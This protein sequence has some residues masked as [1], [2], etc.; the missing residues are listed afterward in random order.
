MRESPAVS[1][2]PLTMTVRPGP[3]ASQCLT[4]GI[5]LGSTAAVSESKPN[6]TFIALSWHVFASEPAPMSAV[7]PAPARGSA[8]QPAAA[9]PPSPAITTPTNQ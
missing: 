1:V 4:S 8:A 3:P 5:L 7:E 9:P 2:E 6:S